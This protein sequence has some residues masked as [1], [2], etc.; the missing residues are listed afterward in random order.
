MAA[1][2]NV[3]SPSPIL[4][5]LGDRATSYATERVQY[6]HTVCA[7]LLLLLFAEIS[8]RD[9]RVEVIRDLVGQLPDA[10]R[11]IL[12]ILIQHLSRYVVIA[13]VLMAMTLSV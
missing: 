13:G 5:L 2:V 9:N 11:D 10:N 4:L 3:D 1:F 7:W 6:L 12:C 8:D